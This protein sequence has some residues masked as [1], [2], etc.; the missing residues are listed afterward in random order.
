MGRSFLFRGSSGRSINNVFFFLYDRLWRASRTS[1]RVA[2][3]C[4]CTRAGET[5]ASIK[6]KKE[7]KRKD[8]PAPLSA[9]PRDFPASASPISQFGAGDPIQIDQH[10]EIR[11]L[12]PLR[13]GKRGGK[14]GGV[15]T[16]MK[17]KKKPKSE[18]KIG[19]TK[20]FWG[21]SVQL[22]ISF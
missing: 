3:C 8:P 18:V 1:V 14:G 16:A 20:E 19:S 10:F 2:S 7:G 6:K 17:M 11:S 4:Y 9:V 21:V 12:C 5:G 22:R 13:W 15:N